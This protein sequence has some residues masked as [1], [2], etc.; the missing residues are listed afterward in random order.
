VIRTEGKLLPGTTYQLALGSDEHRCHL[1]SVG[2]APLP[3][4][5]WVFTT[6]KA[7]ST[8]TVS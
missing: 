3:T 7:D 4:T 6:K 2:G 5:P 1:T 8:L